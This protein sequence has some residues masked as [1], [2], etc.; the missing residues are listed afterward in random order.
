MAVE[1]AIGRPVKIDSTTSVA[2]VSILVSVW[3]W[4]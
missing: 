2:G 3:K 4:T 1:K